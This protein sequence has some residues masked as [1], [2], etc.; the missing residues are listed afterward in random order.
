MCIVTNEA[1]NQVARQE[2]TISNFA[3][4]NAALFKETDIETLKSN[5]SVAFVTSVTEEIYGAI[6]HRSGAT[7]AQLDELRDKVVASNIPY[8]F[9]FDAQF[10]KNGQIQEKYRA[11]LLARFASVGGRKFFYKCRHADPTKQ[12]PLPVL[13]EG[14]GD[15][16]DFAKRCEALRIMLV[17][18]IAPRLREYFRDNAWKIVS[19]EY[20][21]CRT[22]DDFLKAFKQRPY[23]KAARELYVVVCFEI[24]SKTGLATIEEKVM[25][26]LGLVYI[27]VL[28]DGSQIVTKR[29]SGSIKSLGSRVKKTVFNDKMR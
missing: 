1:V 16:E 9:I 10:Y 14:F 6:A 8:D 29:G 28:C 22:M 21:D 18:M 25:E 27:P 7:S 5:F 26:I 11:K 4:I 15:L 20:K 13:E 24:W 12:V 23:G 19:K 3:S 2:Q 17:K